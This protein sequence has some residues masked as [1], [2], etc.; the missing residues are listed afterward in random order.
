MNLRNLT[1]GLLALSLCVGTVS[2]QSMPCRDA[3]EESHH[4]VVLETAQIRVLLLE[5]PRIASTEAY[6]YAYPYVY[7]VLGEGKS[8]TIT[9][10]NGT[11]SHGW[12]GS[13]A[14]LVHNPQKQVVRNE[15]GQTF[16]EAIVELRRGVEYHAFADTYDTDMFP[17]GLGTVKPTWTVSFIRGGVKFS[18]NQLAASDSLKVNGSGHLLIAL[19][20]LT[21]QRRNRGANDAIDLQSQELTNLNAGPASDLTNTGNSAARFILIEY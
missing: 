6:C 14:R 5:L 3:A 16:R 4:Q 19:N 11:F 13:E 12:N 9:E 8:S 18:N 1:I 10:A 7:I 20:D 15:S 17:S 2:G 21:L